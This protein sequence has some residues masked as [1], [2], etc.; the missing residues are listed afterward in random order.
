V[1]AV[2]RLEMDWHQNIK[3][4]LGDI[5]ETRLFHCSCDLCFFACDLCAGTAKGDQTQL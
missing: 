5:F 3:R 2:Q 1:I 4:L